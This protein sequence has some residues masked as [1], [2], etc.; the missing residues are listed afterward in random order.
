[1]TRKPVKWAFFP[2]M[3]ILVI[4]IVAFVLIKRSIILD[5]QEE[6]F[7]RIKQKRAKKLAEQSQEKPNASL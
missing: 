3:G 7:E 4:G 6:M 1:M 2:I 5:R